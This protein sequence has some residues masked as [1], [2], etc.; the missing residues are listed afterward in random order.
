MG[1]LSGLVTTG[2]AWLELVSLRL[3]GL[4]GLLKMPGPPPLYGL[5]CLSSAYTFKWIRTML[6]IQ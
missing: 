3:K 6:E 1:S 4:P 5:L 2:L